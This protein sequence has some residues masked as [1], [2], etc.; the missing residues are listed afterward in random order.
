MA[1]TDT[2]IRTVKST[3]LPGQK[4]AD[5]DGLYLFVTPAG[6]YWRLDYRYLGKR[7]TLALGVYPYVTLAKARTRCLEAQTLLADGI[8]PNVAKRQEKLARMV[9][10]GQTFEVVAR[11][12]LQKTGATRAATTQE[13]VIGW[14]QRSVFPYIGKVPI[15]SLTPRDMLA[16][17]QRVEARGALE[18]A[19]RVKQ[20]C[21]Q[22]FRFAVAAGLA[23]RDM[24]VDLKGA[25]SVPVKRHYAAIIEPGEVAALMRSIDGYQGHPYAVAALKLSALFFVRPGEMRSAEWQEIDFEKAEWRIPRAKMKMKVDHVVPLSHPQR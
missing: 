9:A 4:Y 22:V 19:H 12:W 24:T 20:I 1:L 25:L 5:G 3:G 7:K 15:A 21:G 17:L 10:A 6:K 13:K 11:D 16:C 23:E 18:S 14:L 2:F 8:D